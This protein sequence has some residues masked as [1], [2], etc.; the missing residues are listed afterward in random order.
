MRCPKCG[1]NNVYTVASRP[2]KDGHVRRRSC[3]DCG[4]RWN[5]MEI[6]MDEYIKLKNHQSQEAKNDK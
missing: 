5:T 6:P 2:K 1:S 3:A 4:T